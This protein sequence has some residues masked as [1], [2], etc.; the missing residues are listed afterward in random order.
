MWCSLS[1]W[2][3]KLVHFDLSI[4]HIQ[5]PF[6]CPARSHIIP[7]AHLVGFY[8]PWHWPHCWLKATELQSAGR[9]SRLHLHCTLQRQT[10]KTFIDS[11]TFSPFSEQSIRTYYISNDHH[12][13]AKMVSQVPDPKTWRP[14][15]AEWLV[16]VRF[17]PTS[18]S[19]PP[20]QPAFTVYWHACS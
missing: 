7:R 10:I 2:R 19:R 20:C 5:I 14:S 8:S 13:V 9:P 18:L 1:L 11:Q 3:V 16:F 17:D 15:E 4:A 12:S 6:D